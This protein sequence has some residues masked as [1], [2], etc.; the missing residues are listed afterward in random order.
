MNGC[1]TSS[2][3]NIIGMNKQCPAIAI[4]EIKHGILQHLKESVK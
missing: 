2:S 1:I 4:F 3:Q